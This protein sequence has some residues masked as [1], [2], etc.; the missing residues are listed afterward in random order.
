[1]PI[2]YIRE[3]EANV[4]RG[5]LRASALALLCI[6]TGIFTQGVSRAQSAAPSTAS[7]TGDVEKSDGSPVTNAVVQLVGAQTVSSR[8][9]ASGAFVFLNVPY[10]NYRI[11][12]NVKGL[13]QTTRE[14]IVI[15]GDMNLTVRYESADLNGL[16]VIASVGANARLQ[17]STQPISV[18]TLTPQALADQGET[19]WKHVLNEIPGV[20]VG[21][22]N[23]EIN[24]YSNFAQTYP[25]SPLSTQTLEIGGA[26]PYE[27]SASIDNMPLNAGGGGGVDLGVFDPNAFSQ[28]NVN[29]GPGADSPS[30]V[31]SVGGSL[32]LSPLGRVDKDHANFSVSTDAYGGTISNVGLGM[33]RGRLSL[34]VTYS[35][36]DSPGPLGDDVRLP[37]A[38]TAFFPEVNGQFFMCPGEACISHPYASSSKP[39]GYLCNYGAAVAQVIGCCVPF[40]SAWIEHSGSGSLFYQVSPAISA[41]VFYQGLQSVGAETRTT[42]PVTFDPPAGYTGSLQPGNTYDFLLGGNPGASQ[43][44][45]DVDRL[46]RANQSSSMVEEKMTVAFGT[47]Q[48]TLAA[49]QNTTRASQFYGGASSGQLQLWGGGCYINTASFNC[50]SPAIF[51]GGT[52]TIKD[53][54]VY[55][56]NRG[57]NYDRDYSL[58][59]LRPFGTHYQLKA[60]YISSYLTGSSAQ[61]YGATLPPPLDIF[62]TRCF[63]ETTPEDFNTT[64]EFHLSLGGAITPRLNV[65][66]S[67]YLAMLQYHG[68]LTVYTGTD[69]GNQPSAT[70][71][72]NEHFV[73]Q[74]PRLGF[75]FR[76]SDRI[77]LRASMG[78][79]FTAPPGSNFVGTTGLITP[80][81]L[82]C[83]QIPLVSYNEYQNNINLKSESA[84][85]FSAG[86]DIR[87]TPNTRF[88][89]DMYRT[90]LHGQFYNSQYRDGMINGFPLY[91]NQTINLG[92]TRYEG[93]TV[94]IRHEVVRGWYSQ[95]EFGFTRGYIISLSPGFYNLAPG[96]CNRTTLANCT[97]LGTLASVNYPGFPY[98]QGFG[99]LGYRWSA[100]RYVDVDATY[101]GPNNGYY[102]PAFVEM[103]AN[104]E[105]PVSKVLSLHGTFK[106]ITGIYDQAIE[107]YNAFQNPEIGFP[108]FAGPALWQP[109]L[110]YGPRTLLVRLD[111]AL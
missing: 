69:Y 102:R 22:A 15:A 55:G 27:S 48:L 61:L 105:I 9:N 57:T 33:R 2:P 77:A 43:Y 73:Y 111:L 109:G 93:L 25:D 67:D 86:S 85:G 21:I 31:D 38:L 103:N 32:D 5:F 12:V 94:Q 11:V 53:P 104:A 52:Y 106:N 58:T 37:M 91:I 40:S 101:Y 84:F 96:V 65:T 64:Q 89:V 30:V 60:T 99:A 50:A 17:L 3:K 59:Y 107:T 81:N 18:T 82:G 41:E 34:N 29:I 23:S 45:N 35:V 26:L 1:L 47:G 74:T 39:T 4:F 92:Q 14:H 16:K 44:G 66:L 42:I 28:Y 108:Q 6:S 62:D 63:T 71:Y 90:N 24:I 79:S 68:F 20:N 98:S 88:S 78:G 13:G 51:N 54:V 70:N 72:N 46:G 80:S 7:V 56:Y 8:S 36:N 110:D 75:V 10:G 49:L 100:R 87:L 97:N 95:A 76:A 83:P 19:T